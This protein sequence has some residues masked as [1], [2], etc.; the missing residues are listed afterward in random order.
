[1]LLVKDANILTTG[2]KDHLLDKL[3]H[4]IKN[5][6]EIDIVVSFIRSTGLNLLIPDL[7]KA[8][9]K[10]KKLNNTLQLRILTSDYLHITQPDALKKL[11]ELQDDGVTIKIFEAT[12]SQRSF[13]VKAYIFVNHDKNQNLYEGSAFVGSNNI[14]EAALT[15]AHEWCLRHDYKPPKDSQDA[16][17]FNLIRENFEQLFNH[18]NA[19]ILTNQWIEEYIKN[20]QPPQSNLKDGNLLSNTKENSEKKPETTDFYNDKKDT[21]Q[22][23]KEE[24]SWFMYVVNKDKID[25]QVKIV[26]ESQNKFLFHAIQKTKIQKSFKLILLQAFI[27]LDGFREP[28]ILEALAKKS[29]YVLY[30][31]YHDLWNIDLDSEKKNYI[32]TDKSWLAYWKKNP[33]AAYVKANNPWFIVENKC[34]KANFAI[35]ENQ[36]DILHD[37]VQELVDYRLAEYV[38]KKQKDNKNNIS[39]NDEKLLHESKKYNANLVELPY[40]PNIKIA[41]GHFKT[42]RTD[43]CEMM[44]VNIY[45]ANPKK[46]FL[47]RASGDSMN[48]GKNPIQDGDLLLLESVT[49][50]RA[51]SITGNT[52]VIETQDETGDNQYLLRVVEK[53]PDGSYWLKANNPSYETIPAPKKFRTFARLKK[54]IKEHHLF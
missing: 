13:H 46:H 21:K 36:V 16:K 27:Q 35:A 53:K 28:P 3:L 23:N 39:A 18:D 51:G 22:F 33:V 45:N 48:G 14:S 8:I 42:G 9:K 12:K 5:S 44:E 19:K 49:S 41:C 20:H 30:N 25:P 2:D 6:T 54:V 17:Q 1:M 24:N 10:Q 43:D 26:I 47:A 4:A 11:L 52:L 37:L 38:F 50:E 40:Y 29:W 31:D 34:F 32:A 15:S 7:Q